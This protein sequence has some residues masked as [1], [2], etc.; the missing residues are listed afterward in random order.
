MTAG[1]P[2]GL[3]T[4]T[5]PWQRVS[6]FQKKGGV[7]RNKEEEKLLVV[8]VGE[9]GLDES[10]RTGLEGEE[11]RNRGRCAGQ[12]SDRCFFRSVIELSLTQT[13]FI[14]GE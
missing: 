7:R 10:G 9:A 11:E 12:K 14:V 5:G 2:Q 4:W 6:G 13:A 1:G 3:K 8:V